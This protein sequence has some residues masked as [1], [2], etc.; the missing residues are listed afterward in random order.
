MGE[1]AVSIV[2]FRAGPTLEFTKFDKPP[3]DGFQ[4]TTHHNGFRGEK[5][6]CLIGIV[7]F[8]DTMSNIRCH[9]E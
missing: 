8:R 1:V 3:E 5:P 7:F 4:N 2:G 6:I 9:F